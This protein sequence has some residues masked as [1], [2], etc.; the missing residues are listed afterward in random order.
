MIKYFA[1]FLF[2][3]TALLVNAQCTFE[4]FY[5]YYPVNSSIRSYTIT[6]SD[7]GFLTVMSC[8]WEPNFSNMGGDIDMA[9]VKNDACGNT[10][11]QMHYGA[12]NSADEAAGCIELSDGSYLVAGSTESGPAISNFR[13]VKFSKNGTM[14]W[15]S[16]YNGIHESQCFGITKR[17]NKNSAFIYGFENRPGLQVPYIL[18]I[19]ENGNS[20]KSLGLIHPYYFYYFVNLLK[21]NDSN[22]NLICNSKDTLFFIQTDT[23]FNI[24]INKP[25]VYTQVFYYDACITNDNKSI[26]IALTYTDS[27]YNNDG[28]VLLY[29][30]NGSLKKNFIYPIHTLGNPVCI[31]PTKSNGFII[32]YYLLKT[33]SNFNFLNYNSWYNA[34]RLWSLGAIQSIIELPNRSIVASGYSYIND[35][36]GEMYILKLDSNG[37]YAHSGIIE[38]QIQNNELSIYPNPATNELH[39]AQSAINNLQLTLSLFD[40]NGKQVIENTSFTISTTINTSLLN[41]GLYFVRITDANGAVVKMQKVAVVK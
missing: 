10:L 39:I 37:K 26:A 19:D 31:S 32:G 18:E 21:L 30:I 16:I 8:L 5:K 35:T 29:N 24:K 3:F 41:Q 34:P 36:N 11:W 12:P 33:D 1:I 2:S 40:V 25:I 15:D 13:V 17:M 28:H 27:N 20:L 22:Y 23:S 4:R 7:G 38:T 14:I 6:T 9:I